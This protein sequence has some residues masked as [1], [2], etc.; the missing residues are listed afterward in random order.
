MGGEKAL[1]YGAGRGGE[2]LLRE[3]LNNKNLKMQPVGFIDDDR[4]K[5]GKRLQ[6]FPIL[7]GF[8]DLDGLMKKYGIGSLLISFNH[9]DP[10]QL[11]MLKRF[12]KLNNLHLKRFSVNIADIDLEI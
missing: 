9:N 11:L 8:K 6:G 1:I 5:I 4:L 2:L 3:L 7:G 10:A 12:C